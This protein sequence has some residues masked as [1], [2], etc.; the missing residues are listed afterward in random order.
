MAVFTNTAPIAKVKPT[1]DNLYGF[2]DSPWFW[3]IFDDYI[4]KQITACRDALEVVDK[5]KNIPQFT[6]HDITRSELHILKELKKHVK[7]QIAT[8]L[9]EKHQMM[10]EE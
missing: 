3:A 4:G 2:I 9:P 10:L 6:A 1:A 8:L 7:Q 5:E